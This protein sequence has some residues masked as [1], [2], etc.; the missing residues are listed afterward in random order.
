MKINLILVF[1]CFILFNAAIGQ[2]KRDTIYLDEN[3]SICE[4]PVAEYYRVASLLIDQ[5]LFYVG[6]VNDYYIEGQI[7][8]KGIYNN[9]G[10]RDG[11]FTFYRKNGKKSKEGKFSK[12]EMVG[13]WNYYD[14]NENIHVQFDCKN[15]L[16]FTP[17]LI[18]S[19]S[20][21]TILKNGN[22]YFSLNCQKDLPNVF[23]PTI[24]YT[25]EGKVTNGKKDGEYKYWINDKE[26]K[27]E[28]FCTDFYQNGVLKY[29]KNNNKNNDE[30]KPCNLLNL[31]AKSRLLQTDYFSHTN[32]VFGYGKSGDEML[33][34][35][36]V[37]GDLPEIRS[38]AESYRENIKDI[39]DII[40]T[41]LRPY[42][43]PSNLL[44]LKYSYP[45]PVGPQ[46]E[47]L[48]FV[49]LDNA[50]NTPRI[51]TS[52]IIL[53]IDTTGIIT[54]SVFKGNLNTIEINKMNYYFSRLTNLA[55]FVEKGHIVNRD[56]RLRLITIL[57]TPFVRKV[58][59]QIIC[60]YLALN[61]DSII[62]NQIAKNVKE[63]KAT[64]IGGTSAWRKYLQ[65]NLNAYAPLDNKVPP[66]TYTVEVQFMVD[67][68][69]NISDVHAINSPKNCSI[70]VTEA[71][72]I[73][74]EG[75]KWDSALINWE[76]VK[77]TTTE[78]IT[79]VIDD[80]K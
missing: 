2:P 46:C 31:M 68:E 30:V 43:R 16:E 51:I 65:M 76:K 80:K 74:R 24:S 61:A 56:L 79:F 50:K 54:N 22:G 4:K 36:L 41:V 25:I 59:S 9:K 17:L 77:S 45:P 66:G 58:G 57:D 39:Y 3:W 63:K 20:G 23:S 19:N 28:P 48:H 71:E 52:E 64:F 1:I 38:A 10:M 32:L 42:L 73:I 78:I 8:M 26:G 11:Y 55:P 47:I 13:I 62:E 6:E 21:D 44:E 72:R 49:S 40:G 27:P 15:S 12:D 69:G 70:C 75:P 35:Y 29:I 67:E 7:E 18:V 5:E 60:S 14:E 33:I 37:N 53:T 34:K